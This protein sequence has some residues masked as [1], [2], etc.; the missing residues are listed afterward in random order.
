MNWVKWV[1]MILQ[2]TPYIV[3]GVEAIAGDKASGA[4]KKQMALD[5]LGVATAGA[6]QVDP[7]DAQLTQTASALTGMVIDA[8]VSD[9]NAKGTLQHKPVASTPIQP[10]GPA[11][12]PAGAQV[13]AQPAV[14]AVP[15][16]I[17]VSGQPL[18]TVTG[19][20]AGV[21]S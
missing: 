8:T 12:P 9:L 21:A 13:A 20:P 15:P 2:L 7:A 18:A 4:T 17:V 14:A 1:Q 6:L 3:T 16:T 11:L 10:V 19:G 5:A